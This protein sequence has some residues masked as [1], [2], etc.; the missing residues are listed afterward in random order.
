MKKYFDVEVLGKEV[1][2][3]GGV[4]G[5]YCGTKV[6]GHVVCDIMELGLPDSTVVTVCQ[7]HSGTPAICFCHT[8]EV[9]V[10]PKTHYAGIR[11]P[12]SMYDLVTAIMNVTSVGD[13]FERY[14]QTLT[15]IERNGI[16][17]GEFKKLVKKILS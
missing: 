12:F 16:T 15:D 5:H 13:N 11:L 14:Y 8:D 10:E 17:F 3:Y 1:S 4:D 7:L 2:I 9:V 6:V